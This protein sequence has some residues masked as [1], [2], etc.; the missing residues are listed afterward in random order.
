MLGPREKTK[1]FKTIHLFKIKIS[2]NFASIFLLYLF[3]RIWISNHSSYPEKFISAKCKDF[4]VW[5][6]HA[7]FYPRMFLP[8]K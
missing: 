5:P 2:K 1:Y 6:G 4:A 3:A 7:T 8:L